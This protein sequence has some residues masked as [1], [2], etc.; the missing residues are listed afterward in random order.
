MLNDVPEI[1][2]VVGATQGREAPEIYVDGPN[3]ERTEIRR[4]LS[5]GA[6]SLYG[7][8]LLDLFARRAIVS[9]ALHQGISPDEFS[10][11]LD[12]LG[13]PEGLSA[14]DEGERI[15]RSLA[16]KGVHHISIVIDSDRLPGDTHLPWQ[17]RLALARLTRDFRAI[18]ILHRA[19]GDERRNLHVQIVRDILRPLASNLPILRHLLDCAPL[20]DARLASFGELTDRP[21]LEIFL[22]G[23]PQTA[24]LGIGQILLEEERGAKGE[25]D[26]ERLLATL[27]ALAERLLG[28]ATTPEGDAL[29]REM[30]LRSVVDF[31]RL[32]V[33][34]R[35]WLLAES[36]LGALATRIATP[37]PNAPS[38]SRLFEKT[39]GLAITE[40]EF[41]PAFI[42]LSRLRAADPAAIERALDLAAVEKMID[43]LPRDV[44]ARDLVVLMLEI[45][46]ESA[47]G[48]VASFVAVKRG[49]AR[50][51]AIFVLSELRRHG[52]EAALWEIS[53]A[54]AD[55]EGLLLL[56]GIAT[57]RLGPEAAPVVGGL[58]NHPSARVRRD[59]LSAFAIADPTRSA[60][61]IARA[62]RDP[63]NAVSGH[64]LLLSA[65]TGAAMGEAISLAMEI[66]ER[67]DLEGDAPRVALRMI[68]RAI[69]LGLSSPERVE[70][71]FAQIIDRTAWTRRLFR[72]PQPSAEFLAAST[73]SLARLATPG[74]RRLL[75]ILRKHREPTVAQAAMEALGAL[76]S[77]PPE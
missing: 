58:L 76:K 61:A 51:N 13:E 5:V 34:L 46:R 66:L 70:K 26:S 30:C 32:P 7:P 57:Q 8:Y 45:G 42:A 6:W 59:A 67:A 9:L 53:R 15:I 37:P 62:L 49:R 16:E 11:L 56:I 31:E 35:E 2:Y 27:R 25:Q 12:L 28:V 20:V 65:E 54:R 17:V 4:L 75:E 21:I 39:V 77:K 3:A 23:L 63:E 60:A 52:P 14:L 73:R 10:A 72:R 24:I 68:E 64:A 50:Q 71:V 29:L 33:S 41:G 36:W 18:P 38:E 55:E 1:A 19:T 44:V 43:E 69:A 22:D 47:A 40:H 48:H 74:A